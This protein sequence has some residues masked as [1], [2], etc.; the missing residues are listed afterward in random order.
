MNIGIAHTMA[1]RARIIVAGN[2][3][4]A[5]SVHVTK[6]ALEKHAAN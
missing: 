5:R 6:A 3:V 4:I 2:T 1:H